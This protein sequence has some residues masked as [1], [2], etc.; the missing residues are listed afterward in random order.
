[1]LEFSHCT[2]GG[3]VLGNICVVVRLLLEKLDLYDK[4]IRGRAQ[5]WI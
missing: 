3:Y 4:L 5:I 2:H 1:M